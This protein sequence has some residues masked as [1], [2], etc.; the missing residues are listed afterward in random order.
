MLIRCRGAACC[1]L[2]QFQPGDTLAK[3]R[4]LNDVPLNF[5]RTL[6]D[7]GCSS[8][9]KSSGEEVVFAES[10]RPGNLEREV[11]HA[12]QKL[13]GAEFDIR[14]F[15]AH[16][17]FLVRFPCA[18]VSERPE[19]LDFAEKVTHRRDPASTVFLIV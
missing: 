17:H 9:P 10:R 1:A 6:N 15:G 2:D 11:D 3:K 16:V 12:M 14:R 13:G 19:G 4:A 18:Q 7:T 8:M 5:R